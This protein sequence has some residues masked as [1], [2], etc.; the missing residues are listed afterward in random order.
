M[1]LRNGRPILDKVLGRLVHL[2]S[3]TQVFSRRLDHILLDP[4]SVV[5]LW[6]LLEQVKG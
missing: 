1:F 5:L 2:K 4:Q 6:A 3:I